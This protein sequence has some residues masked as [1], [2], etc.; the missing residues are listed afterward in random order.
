MRC[1]PTAARTRLR[2]A[3]A[4]TAA[5]RTSGGPA[6]VAAAYTP[7]ATCNAQL[8]RAAIPRS[9]VGD[10]CA[11]TTICKQRSKRNA[12]HKLLQHPAQLSQHPA[13]RAAQAVAAPST[14]RSTSCRS[15]QRNAQHKLLQH[16][17]Q[18]AAQAGSR[19]NTRFPS[20][21]RDR[22]DCAGRGGNLTGSVPEGRS[23]GSAHLH[24]VRLLAEPQPATGGLQPCA[25]FPL[26][27]NPA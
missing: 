12:Q 16:P 11:L 5:A 25:E 13:Q 17:A 8:M 23:V 18:R 9:C 24:D 26:I 1:T 21:A 7:R 15:T 10:V 19:C 6:R 3:T 4:R 2:C 27:T 14:T 20:R 22:S